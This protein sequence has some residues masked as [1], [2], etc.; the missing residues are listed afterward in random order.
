MQTSKSD[1]IFISKDP[2]F[3]SKQSIFIDPN[4]NSDGYKRLTDFQVDEFSIENY[5]ATLKD[6]LQKNK[7]TTALNI[8]EISKNWIEI[9]LYNNQYFAYKSCDFYN[10]QM[11][12][13]DNILTHWSMEGQ[14]PHFIVSA[15]ESK[16]NIFDLKLK[17]NY[18]SEIKIYWID[19]E[20][21]LAVFEELV[22]GK[23][24]DY[25]LMLDSSKVSNFPII[26]NNCTRAKQFEMIF[27]KI[28]F[29]K[30]LKK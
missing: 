18:L 13:K 6:L 27:D 21:G 17:G 15:K 19:K 22:N 28:N 11:A 26:I 8:D 14:E 10:Q 2:E 29:Q 1:T 25:F 9:H 7:N 5:D 16:P 23:H 24:F 30:L 4:K 12:I 3:G 20:K